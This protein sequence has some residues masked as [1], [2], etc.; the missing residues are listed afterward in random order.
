[1]AS[2]A[3][4]IVVVKLRPLPQKPAKRKKKIDLTTLN[5]N[6]MDAILKWLPIEDLYSVSRTCKSLQKSAGLAFQRNHPNSLVTIELMADK[7]IQSQYEGK[8]DL[9]FSTNIRSITMTS[10]VFD[11]DLMP[12][13]DYLKMNCCI[14]LNELNLHRLKLA[15]GIDYGAS[16]KGQLRN[17]ESI[18][19]DGCTVSDI[20]KQFLKYCYR[21]QHLR[22][23]EKQFNVDRCDTWM[24][25]VYS[26]LNSFTFWGCDSEKYTGLS[27]FL[28]HNRNVK[29]INC[30]GQLNI[31]KMIMDNGKDL[32]NLVVNC[33]APEDFEEIQNVLLEYSQ[34]GVFKRFELVFRF[35][36][37]IDKVPKN[38]KHIR[39]LSELTT[40]QGFHG[41]FAANEALV[42]CVLKSLTNL[43]SISLKLALEHQSMAWTLAHLP[44]LDD[45]RIYITYSL[46]HFGATFKP[47]TLPFVLMSKK[48]K[49]IVVSFA[50]NSCVTHRNDIIDLN[51]MRLKSKGACPT[52]IYLSSDVILESKFIYPTGGLVQVKPTSQL[53]RKLYLDP[54]LF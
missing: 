22:I 2:P 47:L 49:Q 54:F 52:T 21:L 11:Q 25:H 7:R 14:N 9:H 24:R 34:K 36:S 50:N 3:K 35:T 13:F 41:L 32:D 1:M 53:T 37:D 28:A 45:A 20:H 17:L 15:T 27:I 26:Y 6:C 44:H 30:M 46:D 42:D 33:D 31:L 38:V 18:S 43:R 12:L 16:I 4:Q 29:N 8:Y 23:K 40:F 48:L 39:N 5:M 10:Y 19:F 51:N